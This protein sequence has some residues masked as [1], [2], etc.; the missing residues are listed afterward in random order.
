MWEDTLIQ[1]LREEFNPFRLK[2]SNDQWIASIQ[3]SL[4]QATDN[5]CPCIIGVYTELTDAFDK[6]AFVARYANEDPKSAYQYAAITKDDSK[7]L[8]EHAKQNVKKDLVEVKLAYVD[9]KGQLHNTADNP[10]LATIV[11]YF[12]KVSYALEKLKDFCRKYKI[13][14]TIFM[15]RDCEIAR[16]RIITLYFAKE[17]QKHPGKSI[18]MIIDG[19]NKGFRKTDD[20]YVNFQNERSMK[21]YCSVA[22]FGQTLIANGIIL[23]D[24]KHAAIP[25][26]L[27]LDTLKNKTPLTLENAQIEYTEQTKTKIFKLINS[28]TAKAVDV[29]IYGFAVPLNQNQLAQAQRFSNTANTF[30][31]SALIKDDA[32]R[33]FG[34]DSAVLDAVTNAFSQQK[35]TNWSTI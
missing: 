11:I 19:G 35:E 24:A 20:V 22:D 28:S 7:M 31:R 29:T 14:D 1:T 18:F 16:N 3:N 4:K 8:A 15:P 23:K 25:K 5:D 6:S 9:N 21:K 30:M 13:T 10:D 2:E 17:M 32:R 27:T 12:I 34:T 26:E 33:K